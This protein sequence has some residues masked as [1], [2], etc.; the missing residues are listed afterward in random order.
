MKKTI[1]FLTM[2]IIVA[3]TNV[4]GQT[5]AITSVNNQAF[6]DAQIGYEQ[7]R[8]NVEHPGDAGTPLYNAQGMS[9]FTQIGV[10]KTFGRLYSQFL[11]SIGKSTLSYSDSALNGTPLTDGSSISFSYGAS[12]GYSFYPHMNV[13]ITPYLLGNYLH[14]QLDTGGY[15]AYNPTYIYGGSTYVLRTFFYGIGLLNQW[16]AT[17]YWVLKAEAQIGTQYNPNIY[18]DVNNFNNL[19][20]ATTTEQHWDLTPETSW[21]IGL[22]SD[23]RFASNLHLRAGI[24]YGY[25]N[26]GGQNTAQM[27]IFPSQQHQ[28]GLVTLGLG[29][30]F[31]DSNPNEVTSEKGEQ[32]TIYAVNNQGTL[33]AGV[34]TQDFQGGTNN[35]AY[36]Q[37]GNVPSFGATLTKTWRA[38]YGQ[39]AMTEAVGSTSYQ[40]QAN[41]NETNATTHNTFLDI[42]GKLGYQFESRDNI[43]LTPYARIAFHRWFHEIKGIPSSDR[44]IDG[45][46]ETYQHSQYGVGLL[47]QFAVSP[48][49]VL[50]A[51]ANVGQTFHANM[52]SWVPLGLTIINLYKLGNAGYQMVALG[53]DYSP[54]Q[55]WHV[56]ANVNY[57]TFHYNPSPV[58]LFGTETLVDRFQQVCADIGIGYSFD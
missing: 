18:G 45:L 50:S 48:K 54:K 25:Y 17:P 46:T 20:S 19:P 13:V 16:A 55:R 14:N 2:E 33:R 34:Q 8:Y 5:E 35:N 32:E 1:L 3:G 30:N 58:S 44:F 49:L 31:A 12:V 42:A 6:V 7:L 9:D 51:D 47:G 36:R 52:R 11:V 29:S 23:Y 39:F 43:S 15:T 26:L 21:M 22:G 40:G 24:Q 41:G 4:Y 37:S 57:W 56:Q 38:L 27:G 28:Y 53:A 10:N